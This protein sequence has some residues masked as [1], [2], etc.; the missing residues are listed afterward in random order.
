MIS[1]RSL[2]EI[3]LEIVSGG[4]RWRAA[5]NKRIAA[6]NRADGPSGG[7]LGDLIPGLLVKGSGPNTS[8]HPF[9]P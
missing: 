5:A 1:N 2:S 8:G 7:S 6:A 4:V 3:E 9:D